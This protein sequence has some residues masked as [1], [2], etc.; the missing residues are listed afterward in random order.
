MPRL[1]RVAEPKGTPY[2]AKV[3]KT[4]G[5]LAVRL[6]KACR[7]PGTEVLVRRVGASVVLSPLPQQYSAAFRELVLG[8]PRRLLTRG[9]QGRLDR[10][11]IEL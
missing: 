8:P 6:P 2:R 9:P 1:L 11:D 7:L 10:E 5:S 3:F 4:G